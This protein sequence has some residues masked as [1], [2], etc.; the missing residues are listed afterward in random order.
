[1][2]SITVDSVKELLRAKGFESIEILEE[3]VSPSFGDFY[4]VL[5]VDHLRITAI[6]DRGQLFLYCGHRDRE[7]DLTLEDICD[8]FRIRGYPRYEI[9]CYEKISDQRFEMFKKYFTVF[10]SLFSKQSFEDTYRIV[11][12]KER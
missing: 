8:S 7:E 11:G 12:K 5:M 9:D 10:H 3:K 2:K 4:I 1:M 6:S